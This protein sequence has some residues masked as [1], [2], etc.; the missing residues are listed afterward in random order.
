MSQ[1][2]SHIRPHNKAKRTSS[3]TL[4]HGMPNN[5]TKPEGKNKKI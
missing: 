1:E 2:L 5:K 3:Y 4:M